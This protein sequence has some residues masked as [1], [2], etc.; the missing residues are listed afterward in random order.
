[1]TLDSAQP[2]PRFRAAE[3][4]R[5]DKANREKRAAPRYWRGHGVR[6][7]M[8]TGK[9]A[10]PHPALGIAGVLFLFG[11]RRTTESAAYLRSWPWEGETTRPRS[12]RQHLVF[13]TPF[14]TGLYHQRKGTEGIFRITIGG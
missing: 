14:T 8:P 5:M 12:I 1:V 3:A 6:G 4:R 9:K 11:P 2:R 13:A 7:R 10:E